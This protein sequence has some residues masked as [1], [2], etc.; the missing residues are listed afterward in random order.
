MNC[1]H[2]RTRHLRKVLIAVTSIEVVALKLSSSNTSLMTVQLARLGYVHTPV[3]K[4]STSLGTKEE[5]V[6][7]KSEEEEKVAV[8]RIL[9]G[10]QLLRPPG[11]NQDTVIREKPDSGDPN[12]GTCHLGMVLLVQGFYQPTRQGPHYQLHQPSDLFEH[13]VL[14]EPLAGVVPEVR[15][16]ARRDVCQFLGDQVAQLF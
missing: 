15:E 3:R 1:W 14:E 8:V 13:E 12:Q 2:E 9:V 16:G 4:P 11:L 5:N 6:A 7:M 10:K